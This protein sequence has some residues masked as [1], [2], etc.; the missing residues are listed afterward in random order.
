M[1]YKDKL[2]KLS[3]QLRAK[4]PCGLHEVDVRHNLDCA[5]LRSQGKD[6]CTCDP[7]F[8]I[9]GVKHEG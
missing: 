2:L 3:E 6:E 8:Y 1:S 9:D 7:E 4:Q 5:L